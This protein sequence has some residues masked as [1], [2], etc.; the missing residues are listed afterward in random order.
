MQIKINMVPFNDDKHQGEVADIW[1]GNHG[2][3]ADSKFEDEREYWIHKDRP[4]GAVPAFAKVRHRRSDGAIVLA[5]I[6]LT[7][8]IKLRK[9][10]KF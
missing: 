2:R 6:V 1:V 4:Q 9:T 10:G 5:N 3:P 7:E 8:L